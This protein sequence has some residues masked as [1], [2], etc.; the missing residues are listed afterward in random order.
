MSPDALKQG[1]RVSLPQGRSPWPYQSRLWLLLALLIIWLGPYAQA[2]EGEAPSAGK[3]LKILEAERLELRNEAGEELVI[4]VGNPVKM[5]RDGESIEAPRVVFN[6]TRKRLLLLGGVR[7]RDKQGQLIEAQ[8]LEL[9]TD[10]ESFEAIQV[11]IESGEFYLEGPIC[12]RAAGQILLQEGYLTPCQRCEQE[13]ADYAFQAQEVLLYP[14]DRII[15]RGV[16][17]LRRG[18]RILYLP[19]LLLFL[20]ERR[21][22]LEFGQSES[23]GVFVSADLPYVSDFGLGFTLLRYF[24]RRGFGF[25]FDHYGIGA[26]QE[27]YQFLYLPPPA[28]LVLPDSDPRKDGIFKYRFS[29]K[30]EEPAFRLEGQVVRD[31]SAQVEPRFLQGAGGQPDYTTFLIEGATRQGEPLYRITLDGYLD[32]NPLALP[33]ERTTPKRLPEAEI[34]FPRGLEGELRLNGRV[35][36]GYYE[37]PS[38]PLNRSA[39]RLGPYIGAGRLWVEHRSS[40]RPATPPWPGFS[41]SVENTFIGRY[42]ST[43]NFDPQGNP[44]EFERLIRW[45]TRASVGQ[46]LGPFGVNLSV[47]RNVV[48]GETPFQFDYERPQRTSRLEGSFSFNPDPLFSLTARASRDLERRIFDPPAELTLAS[49]PFPW[50]NFTTSLSRDLEQGRWGLLR[51]SLGLSP[52]PFSLNLS[53]ERQLELG[54]DRLLTLSAAFNPTPFNF[55]LRTGYRYWDVQEKETRPPDQIPLIARYD[56]LELA[57]SYN[58]PGNTTSLSHSRDLNN[59][60]AIRTEL[61]LVLQE[62]PNSFRLRQSFTHL[63]TPLPSTLN[64]TPTATP[65]FLDGLA[66]LTLGLHTFVFTNAV[67]FSPGSESRFRLG[68]QYSADL[69]QADL[70]WSYREGLLRNPRLAVRA[71]VREPEVFINEVSAEFHFPE[72]ENPLTLEDDTQAFLRFVRFSGELEIVPAPLRAE[73]PPGLSLQGFVALERLSDNSGRFRVTL[74]EFGP[75]FSF[76][77]LEK[78]RL[79]LRMVWNAPESGGVNPREFFLPNLEGTILRPRLDLVVDRCCWAFRASLDTLKQEFKFSF[80]LGGDAAE[81]LF[82]QNNI[83]LP[84]GIRLPSPGGR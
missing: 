80:A 16:W 19:V 40:Y 35:L 45:D 7:Y 26:A 60:Q 66:Q 70:L 38:N 73:D 11:R 23:D 1:L 54:L 59:G 48:E 39:R 78:T 65:A 69:F 72:S 34:S 76:M 17:V 30:L 47:S 63:Y 3:R 10:D 20:N 8:E 56:P 74:R 31:D 61:N 71:A 36:L 29:Y 64:P 22:K 25:G 79:F 37:A 9:F 42:Y 15:A 43:Q 49:R 82:N 28:G 12:Q 57:A 14:G 27:R 21:P 32:H 68:Y 18:E 58:P 52:A 51:S 67:G 33:N 84:G 13:V 75:T 81:F 83:V 41:F 62:A 44:T 24:E 77:G 53:Y 4:L 55:S 6:R 5:D 50:V 2:Q 46:T